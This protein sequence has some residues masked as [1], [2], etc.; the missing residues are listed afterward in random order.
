[1]L[2]RERERESV[3]VSER[4]RELQIFFNIKAFKTGT[5]SIDRCQQGTNGEEP[6]L[7]LMKL[8]KGGGGFD[9]E[10]GLKNPNLLFCF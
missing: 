3:C 5:F 2:E 10:R 8:R 7:L 9:M 1:M 4:E 6:R